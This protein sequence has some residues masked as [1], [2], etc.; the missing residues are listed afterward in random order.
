VL[1]FEKDLGLGG[2]LRSCEAY[3]ASPGD[4]ALEARFDL[5]RY[6]QSPEAPADGSPAQ[7]FCTSLVDL[8]GDEALIEGFSKKTQY[9]I[10]LCEKLDHK[11]FTLLQPG[12]ALISAVTDRL[13][14]FNARKALPGQRDFWLNRFRAFQGC[15]SLVFSFAHLH[16][17]FEPLVYHSYIFDGQRARLLNSFSH[18]VRPDA[19][20]GQVIGRLNRSLHL[21]D[22]QKFKEA[23]VRHYDFG[24]I[25]TGEMS[26]QQANINRFKLNFKGRLVQEFHFTRAT[27]ERGRQL[28]ASMDDTARQRLT[29]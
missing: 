9:E 1:V 6:V 13:M 28:L 5:I 21:H 12:E 3:F 10:R 4:P 26:P 11:E 27:S 23:G 17:H 29:Q 24:G 7:A 16:G 25:A 14:D 20:L 2:G 15:G 8:D 22:M 19:R 18:D